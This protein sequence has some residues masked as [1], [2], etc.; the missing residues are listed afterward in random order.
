MDLPQRRVDNDTLSAPGAPRGLRA[1]PGNAEVTLTWVAPADGGGTPI[2]EYQVR[3]AQGASVPAGTSWRSAGTAL[4]EVIAGLANDQRH[5]FEVRAVNSEGAGAAAR[6]TATPIE[7]DLTPPELQSARVENATLQLQYDEPLDTGAVPPGSAFRVVEDGARRLRVSNVRVSGAKA[8]L[9]L[10]EEAKPGTT[11]T[12]SYTP[13]SGATA[14][15][16]RSGNRAAA[17]RGEA[18]TNAS[19]WTMTLN[20][21]DT[22]DEGAPFTFT[23]SRGGGLDEYT[24]VVVTVTD[25]A[26]GHIPAGAPV[27][28]N[29]PGG[30]V[31][32]FE[33][34]ARRASATMIPALN[35]RRDSSR[36]LRVRFESAHVDIGEAEP[37]E[38]ASAASG[39]TASRSRTRSPPGYASAMRRCGWPTPGCA[40]ARTRRWAFAS[41]STARCRTR[42]RWTTPPPTARPRRARTTRPPR[43]RSPSRPGRQPKRCGSRCSTMPTTTA[44]RR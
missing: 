20:A 2:T 21:P 15:Q 40:K 34:G 28:N 33:A 36:T 43:A 32:E 6:A 31:L 27:R 9:T 23:V 42:P 22:V 11:V 12:V 30:R 26:F 29:G 4:R 16:D 13:P 44:G 39:T 3:H 37:G 7:A 10:A 35:G 14:L 17:L 41:R 25:S 1:A 38:G 5:A 24:F 8:L 19:M 18:A